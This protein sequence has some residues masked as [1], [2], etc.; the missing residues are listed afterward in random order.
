MFLEVS[1]CPQ[2][3]HVWQGMC[4][5]GE[6]ATAA[7]GTVRNAFLLLLIINVIKYVLITYIMTHAND[8]K[9]TEQLCDKPDGLLISCFKMSVS[10]CNSWLQIKRVLVFTKMRM[11]SFELSVKTK[12]QS[13]ANSKF[14][15][16]KF[17]YFTALQGHLPLLLIFPGNL[18]ILTLVSNLNEKFSPRM[19]EYFFSRPT[20]SVKKIAFQ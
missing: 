15:M 8:I 9:D 4:V 19:E 7:G 13:H 2:G 20:L 16:T 17:Q 14:Q 5:A 6:S 10:W 12:V 18:F 11:K 1:V 3:R